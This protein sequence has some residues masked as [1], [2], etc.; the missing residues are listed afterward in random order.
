MAFQPVQPAIDRPIPTW[1]RIA[2]PA[3]I[4]ALAFLAFLPALENGLVDFDDHVLITDNPAY[5]GL[6]PD[7][8]AWMFRSTLM[9]HYQPLT[10][11]SYAIDHELSGPELD[12]GAYHRTSM[13]LHAVNAVLLYFVARRL[14]AVAG[15]AAGPRAEVHRVAA[16]AIAAAFWAVHPLRV[17]SV[18]WATERRDVLSGMFWLAALLAYLR[19]FPPA[20]VRPASLAWCG[21]SV[22]FLLLSLLSKAWGMTFFVVAIVLDWYPLRRLPFSPLHWLRR[23]A[24][25]VLAQK[26]PFAVLGIAFAITASWAIRSVLAMRTTAD[27]PLQSRVVQAIYGLTWYVRKTAWPSDLCA[28]YELPVGLDPWEPRFI[29]SYIALGAAGALL[30]VLRR[31]ASWLVAAAAAYTILV[32]P[33]LGLFQSGDQF[34]AD[35]YSYLSCMSWSILA[36][37]GAV[38]VCRR[39]HRPEIAAAAAAIPVLV[40]LAALSWKQTTTWKDSES[41]WRHAALGAP[42]RVIPRV[43]YG[44]A[45]EQRAKALERDGKKAEA[46]LLFDQAIRQYSDA[47]ELRPQDGRPWYPLANL[48]RRKRDF[49]GAERAYRESAK[50]MSQA[51]MPLVNLGNLLTNDL[52]RPDEGIE[53]YRAAVRE[54]ENPRPG[55]HPSGMPYLALGSALKRRGDVDGAREAFQKAAAYPDPQIQEQARGHLRLLDQGK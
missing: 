45:L 49:V 40:V 2:I 25:A 42:D 3:A 18:A 24:L 17:E 38:H 33:V 21:A 5:R 52:S 35:R 34:V 13:L 16:A 11:V 31:R 20:T 15:F 44:L 22:A 1:V 47:A 28:L 6:G 27:W 9:G 51:Y 19:A 8:I 12:P 41:L 53:A 55:S 32:G 54:V 26:V 50:Y 7:H 29:A 10:W 46:E 48:L 37:A 39:L 4:A 23:D 14:L 36:G 30:V 43:N